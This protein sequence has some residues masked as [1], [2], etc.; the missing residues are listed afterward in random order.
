MWL[1][2]SIL[3]TY[4][5]P[6]HPASWEVPTTCCNSSPRYSFSF[7][8][9]VLLRANIS[10]SLHYLTSLL[11]WLSWFLHTA[12][13]HS[14]FRDWAISGYAPPQGKR[15]MMSHCLSISS[16]TV[17][18]KAVYPHHGIHQQ[19][20]TITHSTKCAAVSMSKIQVWKCQLKDTQVR[21]TLK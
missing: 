2:T 1:M 11:P 21:P 14:D 16:S 19:C 7:P 9:L 6:P 3:I 13:S 20:R 5:H 18:Y 4:L 8:F 15:K 17:A 12:F 10:L